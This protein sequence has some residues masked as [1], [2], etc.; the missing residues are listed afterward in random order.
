MWEKGIMLSWEAQKL[1]RGL[2]EAFSDALKRTVPEL[3]PKSTPTS[4]GSRATGSP[5]ASSAH[6]GTK[7]TRKKT[8][9]KDAGAARWWG[10]SLPPMAICGLPPPAH[11]AAHCTMR[12]EVDVD[13]V[14]K[15][16][17]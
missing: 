10:P 11:S 13:D 5:S 2:L 8:K 15:Q 4:F 17:T 3:A 16:A 7:W 14:T 12:M 6:S 1:P 9:K